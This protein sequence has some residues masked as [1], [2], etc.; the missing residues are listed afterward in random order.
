MSETHARAALPVSELTR[1]YKTQSLEDRI[2]SARQAFDGR[3]VFTTSLG[4]EDQI[5]T[6][7]I[8]KTGVDID[9]VTLDTGR[10]F[11]ETYDVWSRTE[12]QYGIKIQAFTPQAEALQTYTSE[13]G[14]NGFYDSF[15]KRK[16]CCHIRK[17]EPLGRALAGANCW[18]A[19]VRAEQTANRADM[20][21]VDFDAKFE[22]EKVR[23]LLDW[24]F[25]DVR[26]Y[27]NR[28]AV[29]LNVL[30]DKG[31]PSIGCQPCTRAISPGEDER[32][33]RWWWE[34]DNGQECGLHI[35]PDGKLTRTQAKPGNPANMS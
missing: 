9:I 8:V 18:V 14:I 25:E 35:G 5:I 2:I 21:Y 30:H 28:H 22:L 6:H 29:P 15:P 34:Q 19:G 12:K 16:S 11:P 10:L 24:T 17:I 26:N 7:A 20:L 33:G 3:I 27:A 1:L 4:L 23:P 31:M 32:A 13:N